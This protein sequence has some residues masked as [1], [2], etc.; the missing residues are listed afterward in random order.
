M[1]SDDRHNMSPQRGVS[2][3]PDPALDYANEHI[4]QHLHHDPRAVS[5]DENVMYTTGTTV[6]KS[7]IPDPSPL[8]HDLHKRHPIERTLGEKAAAEKNGGVAYDAEKGEYEGQEPASETEEERKKS[9]FALYYA[10]YRFVAHIAVFVVFTGW[11]IAGLVLHRKDK[12][13]LI[14]FLL[15]LAISLRLL[16]FYIPSTI[17]SKPMHLIWNNTGVRF[18]DLIPKK[19]QIPLGALLVIAVILVGSFASE[20]TEDNTRENRAVSLFGLVVI[21]FGLWLTSRNRKAIKWHTVIVGMLMQFIIALF[22]L[23]T[24]AGYDIFDFISTLARELLGFAEKGVEFLTDD[25]VPPLHWFISGVLPAIIFFVS[26]VQVLYY[27]GILQWFIGKFAVFFFW[28][29]RVSGAEAV[30]AAASPFIGQGESAM[31][32]KPFVAHM[33]VAEI[34][35]I[36][37]SGFATIAGSVLVAYI[38]M[39]VSPQA[40]IS[41]CVMSIPAS[42]ATSK[43]RYPEEEESLTAGR[44]VIPDDDE[45]KAANVLHSFA[46]GA[47]LGLKIAG[48]ILCTILCIIAL[49]GLIDGLLTWW[50]RYLSI[51][52]PDLTLE[53]ILGYLCYPVAFLMGVPR[54]DL[55]RVGEL[56]GV[57]IVANEFVAYA[58]LVDPEKYP[59]YAAMAVRS[60]L[61]ATYALCGFGNIG[62]LGIQ[63]GV[64]S[65]ISP[66]RSGDVSRV[67]VSSLITGVLSTLS[68]ATIAGL[69]I[70]DQGKF[71][72]V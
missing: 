60:K 18:A 48:M 31:L 66:S 16:F 35:Q 52:D 59:Q 65:Q 5:K 10:K 67:A 12:N 3:N 27:L 45:H 55:L 25:T 20:E 7:A 39:G 44:V 41:S 62:S 37:T 51:H 68:S 8:E 71:I 28:S 70:T 4:H 43:L 6:D 24:Q 46:N 57:K 21:I 29:M 13:W 1:A 42:L 58:R 47:W 30:V 72:S 23:R 38:S 14:P 15:W 22:V 54:G 61:I 50:G 26:I 33:T 56:V 32:V 63:I 64:L 9:L 17:I 40:L 34:H 36:M 11:W 49:I 69:L 19:F 2:P 53:L